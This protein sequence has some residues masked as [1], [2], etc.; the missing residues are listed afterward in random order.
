VAD[1]CYIGPFAL[2]YGKSVL[3]GKVRVED[4]GQVKNCKL[5]GTV[6]VRRIAWLENV[7]A[8]SGIFEYNEKTKAKAERIGQ[9]ITYEDTI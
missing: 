9:N 3:T 5:S 4:Y 1:S 6:L 7:T 8:K 2:V